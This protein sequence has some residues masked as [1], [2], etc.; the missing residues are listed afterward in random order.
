MLLIIGAKGLLGQHA[1]T[2][3]LTTGERVICA[4]HQPEADICLDLRRPIGNITQVLPGGITHALFCSSLTNIDAC[5][6]D[7]DETNRFNVVHTI[8][9]LRVLLNLGIIPIFFS[10]DLVFKGDKGNYSEEEPRFPSTEYGR[11]KKAVEDFLLSQGKPF[12]IIR[13]SKLY[14]LE[15]DDPSPVGKMINALHRKS[16]IRCADDQVICPTCVC[17]IS[18]A[19]YLLIQS[20]ATGVYHVASPHRYTRYSLGMKLANSLGLENLVQRCSI[21]DFA[22]PEPRPT[23]NSLN[24]CKILSR[25]DISFT[26]LEENLPKIL[27]NRKR[28]IV[29][30]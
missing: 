11:Q 4:S 12:V 8:D 13:M 3:F 19:I 7:P 25:H 23:D 29:S 22:F 10:S 27:S 30:S 20:K 18:Q 6:R 2:F 5:Y 24:V 1:T 21:Y 16:T 9:L 26:S 17:D 14:S 28:E 15:R